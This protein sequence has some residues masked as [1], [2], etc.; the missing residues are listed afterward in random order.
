MLL[1]HLFSP[2]PSFCTEVNISPYNPSLVLLTICNQ[3]LICILDCVFYN[4]EKKIMETDPRM[5]WLLKF[6]QGIVLHI[7]HT[8]SYL[9]LKLLSLN[10]KL[11][12]SF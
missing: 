5:Y 2:V 12:V 7:L 8:L 6:I 10:N 9:L 11:L 3:S 4:A 1:G